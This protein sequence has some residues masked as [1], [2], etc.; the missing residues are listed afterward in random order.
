[1]SIVKSKTETK[2]IDYLEEDDPIPGQLW[3]CISF[4]SPEGIKNCN[5][6]GL[7]VRGV[8]GSRKEA[9]KRADDL[10]RK[11]PDFDVFVGEIGKWLP[12]NPDPNECQDSVYLEKELN[13]IV[14]GYKDNMEKSKEMQRERKEDMIKKGAAEE[15]SKA[16]ASAGNRADKIKSRLRDKYDAKH[17]N[18]A[19][20]VAST[21]ST[22]STASNTL[23]MEIGPDTPVDTVDTIDLNTVDKPVASITPDEQ[24]VKQEN[25]RLANNQKVI[26]EK[27]RSVL[28]TQE[29]LDKIKELYEKANQKK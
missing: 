1:M 13:D 28:S 20:A 2:Y 29:K 22:S 14:K 17:K 26:Q 27:E 9:D 6:R 12:W 21:S 5:T 7:K 3:F 18:T 24:L 10:H 11:Y 16:K 23:G 19:A 15:Q 25:D 8:Y 4:V